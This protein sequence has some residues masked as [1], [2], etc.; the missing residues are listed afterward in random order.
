MMA[1][2]IRA[3]L[4]DNCM[5]AQYRVLGSNLRQWL[6]LGFQVRSPGQAENLKL[7][8]AQSLFGRI[9]LVSHR[10]KRVRE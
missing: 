1:V 8:C 9:T 10:I 2:V 6:R 5:V 3:F 4:I 7:S